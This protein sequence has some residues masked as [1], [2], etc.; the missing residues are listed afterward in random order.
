MVPTLSYITNAIDTMRQL[1][2][3]NRS[4]AVLYLL[5]K[6]NYQLIPT[7]PVNCTQRVLLDRDSGQSLPLIA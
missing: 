3:A 7:H 6:L 1:A 4:R 2:Y 5:T